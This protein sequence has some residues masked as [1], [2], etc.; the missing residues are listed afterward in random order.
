MFA[1]PGANVAETH[2]LPPGDE[3]PPVAALFAGLADARQISLSLSDTERPQNIQTSDSRA[4]DWRY[5]N[6]VACLW[7][8]A[9]GRQAAVPVTC[10]R[11]AQ[12]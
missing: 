6:G 12:L 1:S 7:A 4:A 10:W 9:G 5:V 3:R 2:M 8:E 11:H